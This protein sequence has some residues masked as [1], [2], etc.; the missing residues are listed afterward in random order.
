MPT[1][2]VALKIELLMLK[3]NKTNKLPIGIKT[4]PMVCTLAVLLL[5]SSCSRAWKK[6]YTYA[7]EKV[8]PTTKSLLWKIEGNGAKQA[9]YLFGTIH[10]IPKD[11]LKL[12]PQVDEALKKSKFIV[13]EID[14]KDMTNIKAQFSLLSKAFMKDGATLRDLLS[15]E[16][17]AYVRTYMDE[18]GLPLKMVERMKPLF[19]SSLVGQGKDESGNQTATSSVEMVL[20]KKAKKLQIQSSG[21]E[22]TDFQISLFDKIPYK[23]QAEMLVESLRATSK[24]TEPGN[25][26]SQLVSIYNAEDI[27]AMHDMME[28]EGMGMKGF[29]DI[30]LYDR[31]ANWV[32]P[33]TDIVR[34]QPAFFAVGA[35][36]LG[37]AKGVIA[38][39]R[40]AGFKVEPL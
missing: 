16:D 5:A 8:V 32:Q 40:K 22:T 31:N 37:G 11:E 10:V 24:N 38:L 36:H 33:M 13:F 23:Q 17:Y 35:G 21:L 34:N 4:L 2:F 25:E 7:P 1:T 12:R 19:I 3:S 20:W 30:L 27:Q 15:P 28:D 14:I 18:S 39:L 9:S 29:E 6:P 26:M